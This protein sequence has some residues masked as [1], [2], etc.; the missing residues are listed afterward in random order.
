M[1]DAVVTARHPKLALKPKLEGAVL[2][3]QRD[4][5]PRSKGIGP[6]DAAGSEA[7]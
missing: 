4:V 1:N 3:N 6:A 5:E 7:L 2:A